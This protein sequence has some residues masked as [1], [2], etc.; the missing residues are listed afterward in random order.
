MAKKVFI[1]NYLSRPRFSGGLLISFGMLALCFVFSALQWNGYIDYIA[2][3]SRVFTDHEYWRLITSIF[4]HGDMKHLMS[5]SIMTIIMGYYVSTFYGFKSYPA[6]GIF[7]GIVINILV[8]LSFDYD[9]GIVGISGVLYYLWG[10]WFALYVKIQTHIPLS[11]R[12][13]KVFIV[14]SFLL[15]PEVFEVQVSHLS[16]FLGFILGILLGIIYFSFAKDRILSY[17]KWECVEEPEV[18]FDYA[19]RE[20]ELN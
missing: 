8:L 11:R 10:F 18:D 19:I 4:I 16:H 15:I 9:I 13:M 1:E 20:E 17:E 14:G 12:L 2:K 3:P 6:F 5:N 7:V